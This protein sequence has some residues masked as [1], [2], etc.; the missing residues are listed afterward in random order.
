M[1]APRAWVVRL[2]A[3]LAKFLAGT[4]LAILVFLTGA[5]FQV[6][7][8]EYAHCPINHKHF[9]PVARLLL[10]LNY[11]YRAVKFS[12]DPQDGEVAAFG[13]LVLLDGEATSSQVMGL[14]SFF[15]NVLDESHERILTTLVTGLDP[16]E[17]RPEPE[18][19]EP[20]PAEPDEPDDVV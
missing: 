12:I 11:H 2:A 1:R 3:G 14:L 18:P 4:V 20:P 16:G 15:L 9:T 13:D 19:E 6:R 7:S 17:R 10:A 5:F 8:V